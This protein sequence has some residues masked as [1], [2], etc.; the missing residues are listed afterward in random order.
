MSNPRRKLLVLFI[1]LGLLAGG[2]WVYYDMPWAGVPSDAIPTGRAVKIVPDYTECVIPPNIAPLNFIIDQDGSQYRV[3]IHGPSGPDFVVA[4]RSPRIVIPQSKWRRLLAD[5]QGG[6]IWFDVYIRDRDGQW[7]QFD[8]VTNRVAAEPADPYLVYRLIGPLHNYWRETGI[9]QREVATFDESPILRSSTV[10]EEGPCLNC[11]AF[12][13]GNPAQMSFHVRS[14]K[15]TLMVL[16][17]DDRVAGIDTRT[18]QVPAPA[19]YISWHPSGAMAA[20]STNR[21]S[22]QHSASGGSR[23]VFDTHS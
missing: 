21:L 5:N 20:F 1:G 4:S 2:A 23:E 19:A 7:E 16:A 14:T 9:F 8:R 10:A 17:H 13:Q 12:V 15:G 6:G 3:R 11:H 22:L 18:R